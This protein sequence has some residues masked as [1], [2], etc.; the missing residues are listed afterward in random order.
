MLK[1]AHLPKKLRRISLIQTSTLDECSLASLKY[2]LGEAGKTKRIWLAREVLMDEV[3][4]NGGRICGRGKGRYFESSVGMD[5]KKL[6]EAEEV[7]GFIDGKIQRIKDYGRF[8][9]IDDRMVVFY[10]GNVGFVYY[11]GLGELIMNLV[12][13]KIDGPKRLNRRVDSV[14]KMIMEAIDE[15]HKKAPM[16][17]ASE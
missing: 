11:G 2:S 16:I 15:A 4:K 13:L 14:L 6:K 17:P 10:S 8:M 1:R 9:L 12:M 5:H 7:Y 3:K